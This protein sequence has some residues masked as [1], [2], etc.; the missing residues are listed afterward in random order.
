[1][2]LFERQSWTHLWLHKH[3]GF[4]WT[5]ENRIS[6]V[7]RDSKGRCGLSNLNW[8]VLILTRWQRQHHHHEQEE[9][10]PIWG[11]LV[12]FIKSHSRAFPVPVRCKPHPSYLSFTELLKEKCT[13]ALF[14]CYN[15]LRKPSLKLLGIWIISR[16]CG[17]GVKGNVT[18]K[19]YL[20][21]NI[22]C[23]ES[24]RLARRAWN[25]NQGENE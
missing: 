12:F 11:I 17:E 20:V 9:M 21:S 5:L 4:P 22:R 1:M 6:C 16:A 7:P 10:W 14:S 24:S 3:L 2:G 8:C 13:Y 25:E 23:E 19:R 15:L 18:W